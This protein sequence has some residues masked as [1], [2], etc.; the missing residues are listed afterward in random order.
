MKHIIFQPEFE[1]NAQKLPDHIKQ[2]L[3]E[4][5]VIFPEDPFHLYL[6]TKALKEPWK[7]YFGFRITRNYRAIFKFTSDDT[8]TL[9]TIDHR[10]DVYR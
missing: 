6:H 8:I 2:R 1:R 10:K 3:K 5:L 4:L 7:G 9:Y